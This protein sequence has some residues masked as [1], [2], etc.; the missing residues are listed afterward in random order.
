[1]A[2]TSA[3][4]GPLE[5]ACREWHNLLG[6]DHVLRSAE[7][8]Q[9]YERTTLPDAPAP[10]A[11]LCPTSTMQ[12]PAVMRVA[13]AHRIP[14]YPISR[15]KNWGWGD[16][17]P[18][19]EGQV[20]LD[21]SALD[22]I[23]EVNEELG[24]AVVQ[25][26][27][28]Q[29]QLVDALARVNSGWWLDCT[30]AGPHTSIL[31]NILERGSTREQ[32]F[33]L[34][35]GL[36]VVLADSTVVRTGYGH[37][38][39]SRV[40]HVARWGIGPALDGLFSQSNLG[41]VTELG[42]WLQPKP[43]Y[44]VIGYYTVPDDALE[45]IVD[46]LR[47]FRIRG[48]ISGQPLFLVPGGQQWF[49]IVTL[50]GNVR[51]V[52]AHREEL[53]AALVPPGKIAF[54]PPEAADDPT[55]RAA[56]LAGLGLPALPF[57][58]DLLRRSDPLAGSALSPQGVL[59]FVGGPDIQHPTELATSTDPLDHNYGFYFLWPTC[60]AVG[61]EVRGLLDVVRPLLA[62]HGFP[63]LLTL[64]FVTGRAIVLVV[65]VVFDRKRE[66]RRDA[67]RACHDAIL[68]ATIAT[69]YPPARVGLDGMDHLDPAGT[70][71]W[72]LVR[73]LKQALDPH[74]I[75]APGRYL[76]SARAGEG[77]P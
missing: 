24:Y 75:L 11:I 66:E 73:H 58:D 7:V 33:D 55:A 53:E 54:P 18:P 72:H 69:G 35:S 51:A 10:V 76:A 47:P 31:G 63:P 9:R 16:A 60:P 4:P 29:G 37:Y 52:T 38:P 15:G 44:A 50:Q 30:A 27:V 43:A 5:T 12:I 59:M 39:G 64:R 20:V 25:P 22:R 19:T 67:A 71:Y 77:K 23:V 74:Q 14:L 40:T 61:R 48:V 41:I 2:I 45:T 70:T 21:L 62:A 65:R 28:T 46:A 34:V 13:A 17:C 56:T 6:A 68:D 36:E 1:M 3:H 49:G 8:L 42:F 32:R 26:G 57:F